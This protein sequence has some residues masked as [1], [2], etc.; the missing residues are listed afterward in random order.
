MT[1]ILR[2]AAR[3]LAAERWSLAR[4]TALAIVVLAFG[5]ALLGLS[6]WFI[7]AAGMAGLAGIGIAF[8]VFRPSAGV[9]FLALG[10]TAAR[11]GERMLTHDATLRS[12]AALRVSLLQA[13]TRRPPAETQAL[14]ASEQLNRLT[15][16]VDALDGIALRL[17]IPTAAGTLT[18]ATAFVAL[19]WLTDPAIALWLAAS[20]A[21]GT[22]AALAVVL[23]RSRA[24]SRKGR[25]GLDTL[26]MRMIDLLRAR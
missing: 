6:G 5:I 16:D 12:L 20:F 11:Y 15:L 3:I 22:L 13:L 26:R 9:R 10:R 18:L 4:G 23:L 8:D 24:P 21:V 17:L 19:W 14:R 7:T 2:I 1:A 25:L